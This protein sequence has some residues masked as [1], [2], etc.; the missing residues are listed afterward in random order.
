MNNQHSMKILTAMIARLKCA[1]DYWCDLLQRLLFRASFAG[2]GLAAYGKS[3]GY[4][5]ESG[6]GELVIRHAQTYQDK[7]RLWR[8]HTLCWA[9]R[10]ALDLE[11]DFVECGVYKGF[12]SAVVCEYLSFEKTGRTFYLYDSFE[13]FSPKY[14]KPSDFGAGQLFIDVAQRDYTQANLYETVCERFVKYPNVR[15]VRGFMPDSLDSVCP[16]KISYL[17]IDLNSPKAEYLTL[18]RLYPLVESGGIIIFDD[19]GWKNFKKQQEAVQKFFSKT[20]EMVLELPT[21]QGLVVK[22]S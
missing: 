5:F 21:G 15:P 14:T 20:G 18:E 17:H 1:L 12:F 22:K 10:R 3:L 13:G 2:D 19:Y 16:E 11:G 9:G 4:R 8:L 7:S 6:F